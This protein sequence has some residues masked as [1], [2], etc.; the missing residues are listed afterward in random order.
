MS[1]YPNYIVKM[2]LIKNLINIMYYFKIST[3]RIILPTQFKARFSDLKHDM[4]DAIENHHFAT[5]KNGFLFEEKFLCMY[6]WWESYKMDNCSWYENFSWTVTKLQKF[7]ND[8]TKCHNKHIVKICHCFFIWPEHEKQ[9]YRQ[10]CSIV[11]VFKTFNSKD[12]FS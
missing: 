3:C 6:L 11:F 8:S 12:N 7:E 4:F 2:H 9:D 5:H 1:R 10:D